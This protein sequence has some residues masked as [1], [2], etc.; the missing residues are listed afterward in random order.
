L[1]LFSHLERSPNHWD[2][3]TTDEKYKR[4][5]ALAAAPAEAGLRVIEKG[6][7]EA[8]RYLNSDYEEKDDGMTA[9]VANERARSAVIDAIAAL[10]SRPAEEKGECHLPAA[11][12]SPEGLR[13]LLACSP[14]LR[15]YVLSLSA[16]VQSTPAPDA[17]REAEKQLLGSLYV[18]KLLKGASHALRSY[19]NGNSDPTTAKLMADQIDAA[20]GPAASEKRGKQ[21]VCQK[22]G[23]PTKDIPHDDYGTGW[24][25]NGPVV[26]S[27]GGVK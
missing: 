15:E 20:F 27:E 11:P 16:Y 23:R 7:T 14:E 6:L 22:C 21:W 8:M 1:P 25:C 4:L 13:E 5:A 10:S 19:E 18:V 3:H 2:G 24:P 26:E 12:L 17:L 9:D